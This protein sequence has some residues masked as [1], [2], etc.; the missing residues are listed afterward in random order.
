MT[1]LSSRLVGRVQLAPARSWDAPEKEVPRGSFLPRRGDSRKDRD[2]E[3]EAEGVTVALLHLK[4]GLPGVWAR[5]WPAATAG[6]RRAAGGGAAEGREVLTGLRARPGTQAACPPRD[7]GCG[8]S[9]WSGCAPQ[10]EGGCLPAGGL[11]ISWMALREEKENPFRK[12]VN[13]VTQGL[14]AN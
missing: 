9:A 4:R 5:P 6:T 7:P 2:E 12:T 13:W 8:R 14:C 3:R 1:Q 11:F 10:E